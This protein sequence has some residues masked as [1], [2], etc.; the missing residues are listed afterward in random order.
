MRRYND[1]EYHINYI[2]LLA[3][4]HESMREALQL[5]QNL[6][7]SKRQGKLS[8]R[9][10]DSFMYR[11]DKYF[12]YPVSSGNPKLV[13][14]ASWDI[15]QGIG[16]EDTKLDYL[17][18]YIGFKGTTETLLYIGNSYYDICDTIQNITHLPL[19]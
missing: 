2:K 8:Q 15:L 19:Y 13:I 6:Y 7:A 11:V 1:F 3:D 5:K 10:I 14:L 17:L 4:P 18:R 9:E 12:N 16:W